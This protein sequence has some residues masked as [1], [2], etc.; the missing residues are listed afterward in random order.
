MQKFTKLLA[1]VAILLGYSGC[2]QNEP[3]HSLVGE[4]LWEQTSGGIGGWTFKPRERQK[5]VV[6]YTKKGDFEVV[7]N[8]SL[9][10]SGKYHLDKVKIK[11]EPERWVIN[12]EGIVN[13]IPQR[14]IPWPNVVWAGEFRADGTK[15]SVSDHYLG[16][17]GFGSSF[18]RIK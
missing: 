17:D 16:S 15:L 5:V 6:R 14:G 3:A 12:P 11:D 4:W 13:H 1:V 10:Y 9:W 2:Q 8:D 7:R 18:S